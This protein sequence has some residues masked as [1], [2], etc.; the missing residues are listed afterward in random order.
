MRPKNFY[1][2]C[3]LFL[4]LSGTLLACG[5]STTTTFNN[6]TPVV[7]TTPTAGTPALNQW[8]TASPGIELRYE[9]W[10]SPGNNEDTVTITR[11]N[12]NRVHLK[13]GYQPAKPLT[14]DEWMR[15]EQATA[16]LNGGY[17]DQDNTSIALTV[18]NGQAYGTSYNSFGGMLSVDAQGNVSLR[19]LNQRP[20]DPNSEKLQQATQSSPMLMVNGKRTQFNANA[21]SQRRTVVA[22]DTQ[23]RLLFIVSPS[24]AFSLDELA[25]LLASSDLA[26]KTAL[27]L[28]GGAS[29]GMY[30]NAGNQHVAIDAV[31]TLPIVIIVK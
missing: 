8:V 17:F 9:D 21:A 16:I 3:L 25:D 4:L 30:V 1:I 24:S 5:L 27:N 6:G 11:F 22:Q 29:T 15:Q 10:K 18:S 2:F 19:S 13:V 31:T 26:L 23:G 20:Y 28:D 7:S 12:L 14:I